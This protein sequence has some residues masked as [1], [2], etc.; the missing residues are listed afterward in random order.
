LASEEAS[1]TSLIPVYPSKTFPNHYTQVTGLYPENHGLIENTF[2]RETTDS[3]YSISDRDAVED[4]SYYGGLPLTAPFSGIHGWYLNNQSTE[5]I[6]VVL[7]VAGF[8]SE[9]EQ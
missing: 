9:L 7:N 3:L 2:Y 5:D 1:A 8:Y 4:P 6:V